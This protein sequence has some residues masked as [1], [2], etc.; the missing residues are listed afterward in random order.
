MIALAHHPSL[1]M[2]TFALCYVIFDNW[3]NEAAERKEESNGNTV[4]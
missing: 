1:K 4:K 2:E 3:P